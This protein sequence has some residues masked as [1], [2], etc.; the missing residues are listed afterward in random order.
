MT[1]FFNRQKSKNLSI[2]TTISGE[3][4]DRIC[5][6]VSNEKP[7]YAIGRPIIPFRKVLNGKEYLYYPVDIEEESNA[8][9]LSLTKDCRLIINHQ[10]DERNVLVESFRTFLGRRSNG[11]GVKYK[12]IDIDDSEIS[13]ENFKKIFFQ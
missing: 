5:D 3:L 4:W 8:S 12:I 7:K 11:G 13:I 10:F 6:L 2:I 1:S 9:I